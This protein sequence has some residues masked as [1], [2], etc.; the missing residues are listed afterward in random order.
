MYTPGAKI[1]IGVGSCAVGIVA[2][3]VDVTR[4]GVG[5]GAGAGADA[6]YVGAGAGVGAT[7][8][9]AGAGVGATYVGITCVG[10]VGVTCVGAGAVVGTVACGA[11]VPV[12]GNGGSGGVD[13]VV[14]Q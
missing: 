5:A 2:A 11:A 9:G 8:V 10:A 14:C 7:Y 3:V 12:C 13:G 6:T 1:R 4:M